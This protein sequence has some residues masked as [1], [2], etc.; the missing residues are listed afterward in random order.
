MKK[1]PIS[2]IIGGASILVTILLYFIILGNKLAET[3]CLI[4][5]IGVIVAE[6]IATVF[7]YVSNGDPRKIASAA[8]S[9]LLVP[10]SIILSIVYIVNFPTGYITYVGLY[11]VCLII[12]IAISAVFFSFSSKRTSEDKTYQKA[13][14]NMLTLRK[15][16]QCIMVDPSAAPYKNDLNALEEKLHFSNDNVIAAQDEAIYNMLVELQNNISNPQFDV[17]SCL[18]KINYTIDTRNIIAKR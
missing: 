12:I 10:A 8:I 16:V 3:I 9:V 7:A 1:T 18:S 5:L 6:V 14:A 13:K 11:A 17:K 15:T 2:L 4:T